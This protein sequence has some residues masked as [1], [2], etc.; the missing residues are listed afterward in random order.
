MFTTRGIIPTYHN[1]GKE[2]FSLKIY[3]V[4]P[5][6]HI[7]ESY[8]LFACLKRKTTNSILMMRGNLN[9]ISENLVFPKYYHAGGYP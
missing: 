6:K 7:F 1:I 5:T 2:S 4:T 3:D 9:K 8:R